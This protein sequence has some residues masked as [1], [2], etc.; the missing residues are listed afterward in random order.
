VSELGRASFIHSFIAFRL[1]FTITGL[2]H[3][4]PRH[5]C[6]GQLRTSG[7]GRAM[8]KFAKRLA[9]HSAKFV[10]PAEKRFKGVVITGNARR[11]LCLPAF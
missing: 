2:T 9:V 6:G 10:K 3:S 4:V 8:S 11:V 7:G 1:V 5:A